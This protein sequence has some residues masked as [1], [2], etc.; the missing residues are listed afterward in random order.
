MV[1]PP[2]HPQCKSVLLGRLCR[3]LRRLRPGTRRPRIHHMRSARNQAGVN[4]FCRAHRWQRHRSQKHVH[5]HRDVDE[6][7]LGRNFPRCNLA[8]HMMGSREGR[9]ALRAR[10]PPCRA[11]TQG[12]L[13][14]D[15]YFVRHQRS[16]IQKASPGKTCRNPLVRPLSIGRLDRL[17]RSRVDAHK[18][19]VCQYTSLLIGGMCPFFDDGSFKW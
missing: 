12:H 17:R 11:H 14:R 7:R 6:G 8:A 3:W 9:S 10:A 2:R 4:L 16:K 13:H 18:C 1:L 5:V 19:W 15:I